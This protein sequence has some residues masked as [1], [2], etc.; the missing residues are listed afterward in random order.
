VVGVLIIGGLFTGY[1][2]KPASAIGLGENSAIDNKFSTL[3]TAMLAK[4]LPVEKTHG[5]MTFYDLACKNRMFKQT[6]EEE[7]Q[8]VGFPTPTEQVPRSLVLCFCLLDRSPL[9]GPNVRLPH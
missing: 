9:F 4:E 2:T 6:T 3:P 7:L 1:L 8:E 5:Q